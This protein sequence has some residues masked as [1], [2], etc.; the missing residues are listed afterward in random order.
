MADL[1][2]PEA[3]SEPVC[4]YADRDLIL[5]PN[6][7]G[8]SVLGSIYSKLCNERPIKA[9]ETPSVEKHAHPPRVVYCDIY[10]TLTRFTK[11]R[12]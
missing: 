1:P 11:S 12:V 2:T 3:N 8:Q 5:M 10:P 4:L 9:T 6:N 7:S